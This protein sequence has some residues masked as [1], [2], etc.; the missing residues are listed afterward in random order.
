MQGHKVN[1]ALSRSL[2]VT[3]ILMRQV[4]ELT[5]NSSEDQQAFGV[6]GTLTTEPEKIQ[7]KADAAL[8]AVHSAC[9]VPFPQLRKVKEE[10]KKMETNRFIVRV[11]QPSSGVFPWC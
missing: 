6:H 10:L 7:L 3:M 5:F 4:D 2:L 8:F 9:C 11:T 1:N